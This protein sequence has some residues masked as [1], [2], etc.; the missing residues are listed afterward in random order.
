[1]T[2]TTKDGYVYYIVTHKAKEIFTTGIF[3][4]YALHEDD[5][6]ALIESFD[7]LFRVLEQGFQI[8]IHVGVLMQHKSIII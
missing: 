7:D 1:M 3:E 2:K 8:G 6:E 5:T 4:L